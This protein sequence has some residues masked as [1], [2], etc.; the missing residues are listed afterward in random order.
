MKTRALLLAWPEFKFL[1]ETKRFERYLKK[2]GVETKFIVANERR[3]SLLKIVRDAAKLTTKEDALLVVFCGHG[4]PKGWG[5]LVRKE[6]R[7][8]A[9]VR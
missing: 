8:V 2:I 7:D 5:S 4:N 1:L 3:R 6:P 9:I